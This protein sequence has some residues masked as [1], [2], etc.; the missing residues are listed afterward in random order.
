MSELV[1][2]NEESNLTVGDLL[3]DQ[4]P[5]LGSPRT[6][7]V[8]KVTKRYIFAKYI[9]TEMEPMKYLRDGSFASDEYKRCRLFKL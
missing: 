9:N 1:R 4:H 3:Y 2:I 5:N 7:I 8:T 6:V